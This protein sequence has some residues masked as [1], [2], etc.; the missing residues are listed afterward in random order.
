MEILREK[1][2]LIEVVYDKENEKGRE[3]DRVTLTF[4]D[5]ENGEVLD[6]RFN[7]MKYDT[8]TG[9]FTRSEDKEDQVEEW[10][11]EYFNR[12]YDEL[13]NAIGEKLD[14]Y[15]YPKF[16]S[17]WETAQT[18]KFSVEDRGKFFQTE[19]KRVEDDGIA[20]H[21]YFDHKGNEFETKFT[22]AT[23]VQ[24]R[25]EWFVNPQKKTSQHERFKRMFGV[26][27][28]D[29]DSIIGKQINVEVKVA[30]GKFAY[31]EIK[32]PDWN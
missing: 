17:L 5:V 4:L 19:I 2:E 25:R 11:Q 10:C 26:T 16:N 9:K 30:F 23:Y 7:R 1:C 6:V 29:S 8:E 15:S 20:I 27:V 13:S 18:S 31:C 32:N 14:V 22:Y 12:P 24:E 28:E 3:T 21:I